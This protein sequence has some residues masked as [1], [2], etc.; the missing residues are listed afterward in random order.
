MKKTENIFMNLIGFFLFLS[1]SSKLRM[2]GEKNAKNAELK[3]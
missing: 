3:N 2:S 1:S